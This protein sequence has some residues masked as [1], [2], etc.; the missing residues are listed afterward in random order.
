MWF[1]PGKLADIL[2]V[3]NEKRDELNKNGNFFL[4]IVSTIY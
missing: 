2:T 4:N 1:N 3:N